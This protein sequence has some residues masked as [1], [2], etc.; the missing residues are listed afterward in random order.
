LLL[1]FGS[2]RTFLPQF[3]PAEV[4]MSGRG[5]SAPFRLSAARTPPPP[6]FR[7][8]A[9]TRFFS[10]HSSCDDDEQLDDHFYKSS[11]SSSRRTSEEEA[12]TSKK[13]S[14]LTSTERR[15]KKRMKDALQ[16]VE[17]RAMAR[18]RTAR[19]L[20]AKFP[21]A[22]SDDGNNG[23]MMMFQTPMQMED[24][25]E[26]LQ[27]FCYEAQPKQWHHPESVNVSIDLFERAVLEVA[28]IAS[29]A[30]VA[31]ADPANDK[32]TTTGSS[33]SSTATSTVLARKR[34][35][36]THWLCRAE[37]PILH[38]LLDHW[39]KAA[40]QQHDDSQQRKSKQTD[41]DAAAERTAK[42]SKGKEKVYTPHE[43][44]SILDRSAK[45]YPPLFRSSAMTYPM[46][47]ILNVA[48][49]TAPTPA[50][51]PFQAEAIQQYVRDNYPHSTMN[52]LF[53]NQI[54]QAWAT[55]GLRQAPEKMDQLW[56]T[57]RAMK[58]Q[59]QRTGAAPAASG[60]GG[61]GIGRDATTTS[62]TVS[63]SAI[64]PSSATY[65]IL[66]RFWAAHGN[67]MARCEEIL[68]E[69]RSSLRGV[70]IP[71]RLLQTLIVDVYCDAYVAGTTSD[72]KDSSSK[73]KGESESEGAMHKA[74]A[75]L[76]H[77]LIPTMNRDN[78]DH[79]QVMSQTVLQIF[80]AYRKKL[81]LLPPT[82]DDD[83][84]EEENSSSLYITDNRTPTGIEKCSDSVND[85]YEYL[86]DTAKIFDIL[87]PGVVGKCFFVF[88]SN[89][90]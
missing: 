27:F 51:A 13:N 38:R 56:T 53:F 34:T 67:S 31:A 75:M 80:T 64:N 78:P 49:Y 61:G 2:N 45:V 89:F 26:C 42:D 44:L 41:D 3:Q 60:G 58:Q 74:V 29:A 85:L 12:E 83:D 18:I 86:M 52:T 63:A 73:K 14:A 68:E 66:L 46:G 71:I 48:I 24:A 62:T 20:L 15:K 8:A 50:E 21:A 32:N 47:S 76:L 5:R 25:K 16:L 7:L 59:Q 23:T 84:E 37:P 35:E 11:S 90:C 55:S 9:A 6:S 28:Q 77:D 82:R 79:R 43:I 70:P 72:T 69:M 10:A 17:R 81:L 4:V 19:A 30:A 36:L 39:K 57:I 22:I 88:A 87:D 54:L 65:S 40:K 1:K 33:S